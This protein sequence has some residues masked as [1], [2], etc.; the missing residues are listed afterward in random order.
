M[1]SAIHTRF[2]EPAEVLSLGDSPTPEPGPGE[3]RVKTLLAAIHHHDLWTIR[4]Q[5]GYK[6][7]LPA[8]GGSEAVGVI[9]AL[10]EGARA[11]LSVSALLLPVR[12]VLGLNFS[13]PRLA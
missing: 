12:T 6:P 10:G 11:S 9:D 1:R 4:G 8:I 2:G 7:Q 3:V 5:Y 13:P